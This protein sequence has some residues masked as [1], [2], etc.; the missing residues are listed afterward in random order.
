MIGFAESEEAFWSPSPTWETR[1]VADMGWVVGQGV[2]W[3]PLVEIIQRFLCRSAS[4]LKATHGTH[5]HC[6][7]ADSH[8]QQQVMYSASEGVG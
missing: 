1:G 6:L 7:A 4:M 2:R 8:F 5:N 3:P